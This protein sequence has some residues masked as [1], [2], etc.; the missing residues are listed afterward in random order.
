MSL[1]FVVSVHDTTIIIIVVITARTA[2]HVMKVNDTYLKL[3]IDEVY[4][5]E[6]IHNFN[7]LFITIGVV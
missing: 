3:N 7:S 2:V 5:A 1:S 6:C 4:W